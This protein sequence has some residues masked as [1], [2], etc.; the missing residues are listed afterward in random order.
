MQ[1]EMNF[2]SLA[3]NTPAAPVAN[4]KFRI[5]VLG[6]FSASANAGRLHTG[7][8]L[9]ARKPQ[10][11]DV[12]NVDEVLKRMK[13]KLTLPIAAD[14]GSVELA[15]NEM[16][17]FHPDQLF[18][19][20]E[21]FSELSGLRQRLKNK[22]TFAAAAKE[23][24]SWAGDA[25]DADYTVPKKSRAAA[26]PSGKLSDF[27]RLVG[28]PTTAQ[29]TAE[30]DNL[31]RQIVGP[32][33]VAGKDP[34]QDKLTAIVDQA[35]SD[36]MCRV[37]HHPDFQ[38]VES[39][40]RS[41]ELLV[42][43]AEADSTFE[44]VLIDLTAEELAADLSRVE[45]L[46][47]TGLYQLLVEQPALDARQ[48]P[49]SVILGAYTF[50][51]TPP[52]AEL[53]GRMAKIAVAA[54]APF[55]AAVSNDCLKKLKPEEIHP[56][57]T[58]SWST[59]RSLP[60]AAYLGLALPRFLLRFPYGEKTEPIDSFDF[61]EF[62]KREG[63]R[64][65]LW[66]N[67]AFI[68]TLL[69]AE[70]F[71]KGGLKGMKLGSMMNIGD[72]PYYYYTD[73]EGDQVAL[74]CTDRLLTEALATHAMTQGL[75]PIAALKGRDEVRLTSFQSLAGKPLLGPWSSEK[76][77]LSGGGSLGKASTPVAGSTEEA[78]APA[79]ESPP[80]EAAAPAAEAAEPAGGGDAELDA[81]LASLGG[82]DTTTSSSGGADD[83]GMDPEL[84]A[85]LADL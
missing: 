75:M 83:G 33:V 72:L 47:E 56:L 40:W 38:A 52:H 14:G 66:A 63:I 84:A 48:G 80:V 1:Y 41:I 32:Y 6:D 64:S 11:I 62:S 73:D 81:L 79:P 70:M 44:I 55:L 74:P 50:E 24:Q 4:G 68:P 77:T 67:G 19:E 78:P 61:E 34:Q 43:R 31:V 49:F 12:D 60:E 21:V 5:A 30:T 82:N 76:V 42:R 7:A 46:E 37:I 13:L 36:A 65:M 45:S 20:L 2:G 29:K 25:G 26:M 10:R 3:S 57:I 85:L 51:K 23:I 16:D 28:A 22:G 17:D 71:A 59:L 15:I 39:L 54:Q 27:A 69:L 8:E 9:G 58:E 18:E 53:L 35:L